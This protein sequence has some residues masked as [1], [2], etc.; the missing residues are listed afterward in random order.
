[1]VTLFLGNLRRDILECFEA[2]GNK[3]NIC[4]SKLERG[5]LRNFL[6]MGEFMSQSYTFLF[7][8]Q[9][10]NTAFVESVKQYFERFGSLGEKENILT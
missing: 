9:I 1:M 4:R 8:D 7:M 3:G 2:Y 10:A 5:I 6:M